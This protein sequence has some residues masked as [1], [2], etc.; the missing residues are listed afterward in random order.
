[1]TVDMVDSSTITFLLH[2]IYVYLPN[3]LRT[4]KYKIPPRWTKKKKKTWSS[5]HSTHIQH[6]HV[7]ISISKTTTTNE[8]WTRK[9]YSPVVR[10]MGAAKWKVLFFL[11]YLLR[12]EP[13]AIHSY[14][15]R[16]LMS[17]KRC[18]SSPEF[19][20]QHNFNK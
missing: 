15:A 20:N 2:K 17:R 8:N 12:R 10:W 13:P 16:D 3:S 14:N 4:I 19:N 11:H 5:V 7:C 18:R 1:M 9:T 6:T